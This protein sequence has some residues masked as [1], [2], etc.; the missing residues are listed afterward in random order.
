MDP[1]SDVISFLAPRSY[2]V[3]GFEAGGDWSIR[4]DAFEGIK[5]YAVTSGACWIAVEGA[6]E[7]VL[8][9]QGDCFLLPHGWP[10]RVASDP[11]LPRDD[12]KRHFLGSR[13]GA[14]V[15]LNDSDGV[16]VL[17]GHFQLAGPQAA[18][19]LGMLPPIVHLQSETDRETLRWA[20]DRMRQEL[21]DPKP[22]GLLI[23][24]QLATMIF[25]QALRLHL[26]EGKGVGWLFALSDKPV[27]AAIAAIHREPAR[28]WTVAA[29][30]AE[31]GMSRSGFAARFR[32]LVGDGPIEYLTRWRMLLA[33]R[34]V[35][36]GEP[37]GAIA[38]SLGYESESAFS[39]A[40]KRVMGSTPRHH[41][42]LAAVA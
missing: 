25:V 40:F 15:R 37:I 2:F 24:Q 30:A 14:L 33:G 4:F 34:S 7:P 3:G 6:G 36:R 11:D 23:L 27:G 9:K 5:C 20:F 35:S 41:A 10:F 21:V 31:V 19:L 28:R 1:L 8:L 29:L 17:G 42:R 39:T 12:W 26:D 22:G 38:R 18:M 13:D 32:Q 16:T